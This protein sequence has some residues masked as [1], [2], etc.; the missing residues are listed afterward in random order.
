M[1]HNRRF[2]TL[3]LVASM[4]LMLGATPAGA[5]DAPDEG[6]VD[7]SVDAS[8]SATISGSAGVPVDVSSASVTLRPTTVGP[9]QHDGETV[10]T[11]PI[12]AG[13]EFAVDVAVNADSTTDASADHDLTTNVDTSDPAEAVTV[14]TRSDEQGR[15]CIDIGVLFDATVTVDGD[16][17]AVASSTTTVSAQV[18][19]TLDGETVVAHITDHVT[20]HGSAS[21]G[22]GAEPIEETFPVETGAEVCLPTV[23]G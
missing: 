18:E 22:S 11:E 23:T 19:A 17:A 6:S 21:A 14:A 20:I 8:A 3:G 5:L 15:T 2:S 10:E 13:T 4:A 9:V 12:A 16:A 1:H 7:A